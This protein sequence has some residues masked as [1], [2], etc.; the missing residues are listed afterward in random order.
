MLLAQYNYATKQHSS[1]AV[2][3]DFGN[4]TSINQNWYFTYNTWLDCPHYFAD[5]QK[6]NLG[7]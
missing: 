6:I 4:L 3:D 2:M 7:A 5:N 1:F